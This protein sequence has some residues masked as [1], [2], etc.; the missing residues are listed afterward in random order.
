[1]AGQDS[2]ATVTFDPKLRTYLFLQALCIGVLTVVGLFLLPF[3]VW[4]CWIWSGAYFRSLSCTLEPRRL[5]VAS[6]VVFRRERTIP[7]DK[8]QDVSLMRGPLLDMLGLVKL[9]VETAGSGSAGDGAAADLTGVT[10]ALA[11]Q[12]QVLAQRDRELDTRSDAPAA[13][14]PPDPAAAPAMLGEILAVLKRIEQRLP[15][16]AG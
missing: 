7:L 1:M 9:K 8:I 16:A 13:P 3:L 12:E 2:L 15:P 14:V 6:G 4:G 5:R 11:F 10:D